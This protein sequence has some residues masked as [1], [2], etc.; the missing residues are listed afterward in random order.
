LC[1]GGQKV[2]LLSNDGET[3]FSIICYVAAAAGKERTREVEMGARDVTGG[4]EGDK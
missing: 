1:G 2:K 4:G 3:W